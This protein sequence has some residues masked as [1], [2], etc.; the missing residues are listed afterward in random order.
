MEN[1]IKAGMLITILTAFAY[2]GHYSGYNKGKVD[3]Y[4]KRGA[5]VPVLEALK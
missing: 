2:A 3:L 4:E 1:L 5:C